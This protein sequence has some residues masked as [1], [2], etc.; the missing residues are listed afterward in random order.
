MGRMGIIEE[1]AET[2]R[3]QV[4]QMGREC[5]GPRKDAE[6]K[7]GSKSKN[8]AARKRGWASGK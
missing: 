8:G 3:D 7:P 2:K 5:V 6:T 4:K 1:P